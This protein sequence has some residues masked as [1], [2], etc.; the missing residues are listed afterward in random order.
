[1]ALVTTTLAAAV[2]ITDN[3]ITVASATSLTAGRLIRI[4]GEY[5][6]INQ[7]YTGGV[8]VGVLRGQEGSVTAAHQSGANVVT[9][10]ASD[11]ASAPS[12]VNE[13][14]L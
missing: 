11:L 12:E 4:D 13:G 6:E 10:L 3:V 1:M 8:S 2:A 14:V 7:A 9:A 5:M